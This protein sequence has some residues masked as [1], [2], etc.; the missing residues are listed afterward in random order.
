M[1]KQ[2]W[3]AAFAL[4]MLLFFGSTTRTYAAETTGYFDR[5]ENGVIVGWGWDPSTPNTAV[6]VNVTVTNEETGETIHDFEQ[7]AAVYREDLETE[8]IGNGRHGFRISV[9]WNSMEDGVYRIEGSTDG[10]VF[11]NTLTYTVG[12]ETVAEET[13]ETQT[14][15]NLVSLGYFRT[16]GYCPCRICSEGYGRTTSTGALATANH[17]IAVDPRVIPLGSKIMINGI[18]YIAEDRGGGVKGNHID[19]YFDTHSQTTQHGNQMQE[20]FLLRS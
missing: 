6:P 15:T 19:I 7:T 11:E 17:T 20:V 1:K 16:T 9:N 14:D 18:V 3:Y 13:A 2:T 4:V 5:I 8:G 10:R 12:E